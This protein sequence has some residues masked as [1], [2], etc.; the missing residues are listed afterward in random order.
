MADYEDFD[1]AD[2]EKK[3]FDY[4]EADAKAALEDFFEKSR[5]KVFFSRQVEVIHEDKYFHWITNRAIRELI[6]EGK[7]REEKRKLRT[8]GTIHLIWHR[9]YRYYKRSAEHLV[10][11]VEEYADPRIGEVIGHHA[12][13]MVLA[14][15]ARCKFIMQGENTREFRGK[16]WEKSEHDLDFIFERDLVTYGIE[17]KN[18]LGYMGYEEFGIKIRLSVHLGVRPVFAVRM[19][20]KTWIKELIDNGGYAMI[21][22]YQLYPVG[23]RELAR[24]VAGELGLPVDAPRALGSGTM[25]RFMRWD[26]KNV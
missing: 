18:T 4:K 25:E 10:G 17:V 6:R 23:Q 14:G 12:E 1:F 8:G 19:M 13:G 21:L 11:L 24:R 5:E 16:I 15:F 22:K 9:N 20:P 3:S 2:Y 7:I 26:E